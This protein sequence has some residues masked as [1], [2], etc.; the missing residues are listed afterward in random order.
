MSWASEDEAEGVLQVQAAQAH[1]RRRHPRLQLRRRLLLAHLRLLAAARA[2][3]HLLLPRRLHRRRRRRVV[4]GDNV[5]VGDLL[6]A[7]RSRDVVGLVAVAA[8]RVQVP[9]VHLDLDQDPLA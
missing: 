6:G 8:D 3:P 4:R 9:E 1:D 2:Q 5:E 7:L